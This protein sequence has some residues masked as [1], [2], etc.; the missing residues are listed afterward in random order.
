MINSK[1]KENPNIVPMKTCSMYRVLGLYSVSDE[2]AHSEAGEPGYCTTYITDTTCNNTVQQCVQG[3]SILYT[4]QM[5]TMSTLY[6]Y[7]QLHRQII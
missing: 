4:I 7:L 1:C 3:S 2:I 5:C 6:T